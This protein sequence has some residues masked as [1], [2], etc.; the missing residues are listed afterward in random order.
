MHIYGVFEGTYSRSRQ[1]REASLSSLSRQTNN[2]TLSSNTLRSRQTSRSLQRT[3]YYFRSLKHL[4]ITVFCTTTRKKTHRGTISTRATLLSSWSW[5][6][7]STKFTR[8]TS[9]SCLTTVS[10]GSF[11]A[12]WA[13][14]SRW[15]G[16][17]LRMEVVR[18]EVYGE[19]LN[20]R[21]EQ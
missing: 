21:L 12:S 19:L 2:T 9:R 7:S 3:V 10:F 4:S 5:R 15:S 8:A 6:S 14:G 18:V 17:A 11:L 1:A 20:F 16:I 13:T